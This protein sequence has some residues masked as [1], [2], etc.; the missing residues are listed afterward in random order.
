MKT[1][2]ALSSLVMGLLLVGCSNTTTV[3]VPV[4][5]RIDLAAFPTVGLVTFSSNG[6]SDLQRFG[7]QKFLSQVQSAQPGTRV[8]ELGSEAQ[9]LAS[10][11]A[12]SFDS[13]T[14]RAIKQKHGVDAIFM[15][16]IDV[17]KARPQIGISSAF[18]KNVDVRANVD[19][20]LSA[21]LVET[22]TGATLWSNSARQSQEV[23]NA[24]FNDRGQGFF[25]ASDPQAAYGNMVDCMSYE[26]TDD[27]R[28]HFVLKRVPKDQLATAGE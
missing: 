1:F 22:A 13:A 27:F 15:G 25:G 14:L 11:N 18:T 26:I 10:V 9:V 17:D 5:P 28:T 19:A 6:N 24:N 20:A 2:R 12:R 4:P 16:R 3:K 23:A 21:R 7:T 8:V